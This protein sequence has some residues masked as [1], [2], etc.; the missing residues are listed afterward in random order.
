M[1]VHARN[2]PIDRSDD[3]ALLRQIA[4]LSIGYSGAE[5]AN[6]LNEAAILAVSLTRTKCAVRPMPGV[7]PHLSGTALSSVTA[8]CSN[9]RPHAR[10][11]HRQ[12]TDVPHGRPASLC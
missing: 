5:L 4:D 12:H 2:K 1:Q 10:P 11:A 9:S 7:F 6:L 3:D 8:F